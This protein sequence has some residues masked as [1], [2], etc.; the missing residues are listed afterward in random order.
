[1][2]TGKQHNNFIPFPADLST[3]AVEDFIRQLDNNHDPDLRAVAIDCSQLNEVT[4]SHIGILWMAR[5]HC[6][7]NG[8]KTHLIN[9]AP[10]L[11]HVLQVLDMREF[12]QIDDNGGAAGGENAELVESEIIHQQY[13]DNFYAKKEDINVALKKFE[14]FLS[15]MRLP[16]AVVFDLKTV[17]YEVAHNIYEHGT[18]KRHDKITFLADVY[19]NRI[20]MEFSD[21]GFP[22]DPTSRV[23]NQHLKDAIN[24]RKIRGFGLMMIKKLVDSISYVYHENRRNVLR[25]E[26]IWRYHIEQE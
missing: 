5:E 15:R 9:T 11:I 13:D 23:S 25:L 1:V 4:S 21:R 18:L 10:N 3:E 24:G 6:E 17:F 20:I 14:S 22:F 16:D 7:K 26:K 12:F 2:Q 8:K 19:K